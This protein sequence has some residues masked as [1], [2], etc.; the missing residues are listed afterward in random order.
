MN[1]NLSFIS[2]K[3]TV[4]IDKTFPDDVNLNELNQEKVN[5][6]NDKLRAMIKKFN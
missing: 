4:Q 2:N 3:Y 5:K 6:L 1:T